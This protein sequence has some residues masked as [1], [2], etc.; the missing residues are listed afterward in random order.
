MVILSRNSRIIWTENEV[1]G[2]H[3][4]RQEPDLSVASPYSTK[5]C[6]TPVPTLQFRINLLCTQP[7]VAS[8]PHAMPQSTRGGVAAPL[9]VRIVKWITGQSLTVALPLPSGMGAPPAAVA[10]P[11]DDRAFW[12][13]Y[14]QSPVE[15]QIGTIL[16]SLGLKQVN[17]GPGRPVF[18]SDKVTQ[19]AGAV[20]DAVTRLPATREELLDVASNLSN[21]RVPEEVALLQFR[22]GDK[23]WGASERRTWLLQASEG[24]AEY[25]KDLFFENSADRDV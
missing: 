13:R 12:K 25:H 9:S 7:P 6:N 2:Q 24:K 10:L 11:T 18:Q 17:P 5:T 21:L 15:L 16:L 20:A 1:K 3:H 4:R 19:L 23:I 8:T 14:S 22:F